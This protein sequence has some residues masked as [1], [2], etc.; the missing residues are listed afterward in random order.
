MAPPTALALSTAY[1]PQALISSPSLPQLP[2]ARSIKSLPSVTTDSITIPTERNTRVNQAV[3][4]VPSFCPHQIPEESAALKSLLDIPVLS[5][6]QP[7]KPRSIPH[8]GAR[9]EEHTSELQSL[10]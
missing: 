7:K 8:N 1:F 3:N 10:R 6:N 4:T 2:V 9:S 5:T